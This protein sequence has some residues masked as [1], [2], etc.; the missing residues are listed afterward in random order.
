MSIA[1]E[2]LTSAPR[3]SDEIQD[4]A[5]LHNFQRTLSLATGLSLAVVGAEGHC[6]SAFSH[7]ADRIH[8][9]LLACQELIQRILDPAN[10]H[11]QVARGPG[12]LLFMCHPVQIRGY[13]FG[14]VLAGPVW[15]VPPNR[16][17]LSELSELV[18]LPVEEVEQAVR[19]HPAPIPLDLTQGRDLTSSLA[20]LTAQ[21]V[22]DRR[23]QRHTLTTLASLYEIGTAISSSL[24]LEEVL[25]TVLSRSLELFGA[26]SGSLM[27]LDETR[28]ELKILT[29]EGPQDAVICTTRIPLGEDAADWVAREG[30]P[31]IGGG[32]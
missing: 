7:P 14:Y 6:L 13:L 20:D 22:Y 21:I 9:S 15:E 5:P 29:Q 2:P 23:Q 12:G 3:G 4:L 16:V 18:H 25:S 10:A 1:F 26:T 32:G 19:F 27:L 30:E 17:V 31:R 8:A 28:G 24:E 11:F